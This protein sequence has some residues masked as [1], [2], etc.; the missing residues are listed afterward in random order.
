MTAPSIGVKDLLVAAAVGVSPPVSG[1]WDIFISQLPTKPNNV[2]ALYDTGGPPPNPKWLLDRPDVTAI[3]RGSDY[4]TAYDKMIAVR[5]ALLGLPAQV[6]NGDRWDGIIQVGE[7][8]F[9]GYDTNQNAQFT[10]TFRMWIEPA[11][12]AGDYREPL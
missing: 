5:N 9:T 7:G 11:N 8:A 12:T 6:I 3:I 1:D 4:E 2:I 10:V